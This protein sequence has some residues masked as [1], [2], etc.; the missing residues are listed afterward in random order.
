MLHYSIVTGEMGRHS[1][2]VGE[3][4]GENVGVADGMLGRMSE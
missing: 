2:D 3:N 1:W 4:V